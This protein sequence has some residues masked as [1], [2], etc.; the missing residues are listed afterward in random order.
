MSK[1]KISTAVALGALMAAGAASTAGAQGYGRYDD[2]RFEAQRGDQR[3][4]TS[5]VD[6]LQWRIQQ[7]AR[8]RRISWGQAQELQRELSRVQPLA[9]RYQTG[10]ARPGEVTLL[11]RTVSRIEAATS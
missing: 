3:L 11:E 9:Y 6:G 5:Y 1:L 2:H 8:E 4:T 7:A 10:Q